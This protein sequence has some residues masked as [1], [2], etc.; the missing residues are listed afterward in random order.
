MKNKKTI[1][2]F[3]I[4][5]SGS[6][7]GMEREVTSG[8]NTQL[9]TLQQLRKELPNQEFIVSLTFFNEKIEDVISFGNIDQLVPLNRQT[10]RPH[11]LTSLLDA[12]GKSINHTKEKYGEQI[13]RDEA[14]VVMVIITDGHEN[15]SKF[16]NYHN[17]AGMIKELDSTGR[18]TFSFL[19]ADLDAIHTSHML[20]IRRE[21]VLSFN[22]HQYQ[23][24]MSDMGESMRIYEHSKASGF[25]KH[26]FFD[27]FKEKDRRTDK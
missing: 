15:A 26:D 1:Y 23:E 19:G 6:M 2:H 12:I 21:N 7:A 10:Y 25:V 18:W 14:S 9:A 5:R 27:N 13:Q 4:D 24:M 11:G 3:I 16:Y 22:K 8:F 17:V 20:N